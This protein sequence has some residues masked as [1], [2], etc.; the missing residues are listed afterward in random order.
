MTISRN[1]HRTH[2]RLS[3][4]PR[5]ARLGIVAA[6]AV[7]SLAGCGSAASDSGSGADGIKTG[8]GVDGNSIKLG[9]L[10][11]L[12][13]SFAAT[14]KDGVFGAQLYWDQKNAAGGV[15]NR[16]QV[17]SEVLDDGLNVQTATTQ[18]SRL[19]SEVLAI[20]QLA[21]S[22]IANAL[23]PRI[24]QDQML[25]I[26]LGWSSNLANNP[27]Y[28]L[29]GT[30]YDLETVNGLDYL[31]Q[32]GLIQDGDTIG[33]I[34]L[35]GEYGEDA[36][37]GAEYVAE[38]HR[39]TLIKQTVSPTDTD[40]ASQV[41]ALRG[42]GVKAVVLTTTPLQ[43]SAAASAA[44]AQGLD[45]PLLG[46]TPSYLPS[47]LDSP[48]RGT[49]VKNLYVMSPIAPLSAPGAREIVD[50]FTAQRPDEKATI[51]IVSGYVSAQ[52]MDMVLE[53]AC[54]QRDMTRAGVFAAKQRL[55]G[56]TVGG[57][58]PP[59]DYSVEDVAPTRQSFI[60][61]P[62]PAAVGGMVLAAA[63]FEGV[64]AKTFSGG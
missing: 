18:Y 22:S 47:L 25:T 8:P 11:D 56:V 44:A 49:L 26:P 61:R 17:E 29:L 62:D 58:T 32:Q 3:W 40:L 15:C 14:G 57:L 43:T 48:V 6:L 55:T 10:T 23:G 21:G 4:R 33:Q 64:D 59:L 34:A 9:V 30:T 13:A 37:R 20:E 45:V 12:T 27:N 5:A 46:N 39:L 63:Q 19:R 7:T 60:N 50:A 24:Q 1:G 36:T 16:Y 2:R 41:T 35:L 42:K 53:K 51:G 38:A 31:L 54:E 28:A 52:V